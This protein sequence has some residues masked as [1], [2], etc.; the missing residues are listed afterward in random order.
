MFS[1]CLLWFGMNFNLL[2]EFIAQI[3]LE[4]HIAT[5]G[6]IGYSFCQA[7]VKIFNYMFFYV[8]YVPMWFGMNFNLLKEFIAQILFGK[9]T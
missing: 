8:F 7:G 5:L 6:H 9:T 4:N 3:L 2:K 1:M